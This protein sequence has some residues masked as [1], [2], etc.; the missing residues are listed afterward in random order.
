M[1]RI[2]GVNIPPQKHVV[3]GLTAVYG[4]GRS[5]AVHICADAN[6]DPQKKV[7]DLTD[8]ELENLRNE[9]AKF[10]VEGDLRR[11]IAVRRRR[12]RG[13]CGAD[14]TAVAAARQQRRAERGG[15]AQDL[16]AGEIGEFGHRRL[17]SQASRGQWTRSA[18]TAVS[19]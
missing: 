10:K 5:R 1:A 9:I 15:T 18:Q 7:K 13:V 4:I 3:I 14:R 11:E 19:R 17:R 2:A 12:L 6:V 8:G 16:A